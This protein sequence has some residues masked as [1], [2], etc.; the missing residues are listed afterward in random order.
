MQH[1][2]DRSNCRSQSPTAMQRRATSEFVVRWCPGP[3]DDSVDNASIHTSIQV[4]IHPWEYPM[5]EW[6]HACK[7]V[8]LLSSLRE[9]KKRS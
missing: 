7:C 4:A 3:G 1:F 2:T 5:S 8:C 9:R 6:Q